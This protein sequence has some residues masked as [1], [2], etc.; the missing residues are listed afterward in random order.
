LEVSLQVQT[1][2]YLSD[3]P[4]MKHEV[5]PVRNSEETAAMIKKPAR[6]TGLWTSTWRQETQDSD[7]VEWCRG[8]DFGNPD[9][10]YW[11]LLTPREDI[12][13]YVIDCVY[14]LEQLLHTYPWT[15]PLLTEL[16]ERYKIMHLEYA[17]KDA[18]FVQM[19]TE[20]TGIQLPSMNLP[21]Y[22]TIDFE[23]LSQ[24]YDGIWLTEQGN[25]AVHLP[26]ISEHDLN[27]WDC[28]C[29]LWF[30]WCFEHVE[31]IKPVA[32]IT[33]QIANNGTI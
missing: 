17:E 18:L 15:T 20:Q 16:N 21:H 11:Y 13:L 22:A 9:G 32:A 29:I 24:D 3:A 2:L 12:K 8:E 26:W 14:D 23:K 6:H 25:A 27:S 19:L 1:Q 10:K 28:E 4:E 30:R 7:W 33:E 5:I 31:T